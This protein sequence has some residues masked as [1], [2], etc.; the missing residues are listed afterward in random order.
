MRAQDQ[1]DEQSQKMRQTYVNEYA[2]QYANHAGDQ[3]VG[4]NDTFD[5]DGGQTSETQ[6]YYKNLY[7]N[8][9]GGSQGN[10]PGGK[11]HSQYAQYAS[12]YMPPQ[13]TG[14]GGAGVQNYYMNKFVPAAYRDEAP[15]VPETNDRVEPRSATAEA[16]G[17]HA[18]A[19]EALTMLA[20]VASNATAQHSSD[21]SEGMEHMQKYGDYS[22]YMNKYSGGGSSGSYGD[23]QKDMDEYTSNNSNSVDDKD[24][25]EKKYGDW[26]KYKKQYGD[27][28]KYK[29]EGERYKKKYQDEYANRWT[30]TTV[31]AV[32]TTVDAVE[33]T[34]VHS[35]EAKVDSVQTPAPSEEATALASQV[36][37]G[38][39]PWVLVLCAFAGGSIPVALAAARRRQQLESCE[40]ESARFLLMA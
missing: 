36:G 37:Q 21:G 22:R 11:Y 26:E 9:Y 34:P 30:S 7:V 23:Y 20:E 18:A 14:P 2:G 16:N 27:W 6:A 5:A 4:H 24:K 28:Q 40:E 12:Q 13:A 31:N 35:D 10:H 3:G 32:P 29:K 15:P 39:S 25:Y 19:P 8:E 38:R 1:Q 33:T 17:P